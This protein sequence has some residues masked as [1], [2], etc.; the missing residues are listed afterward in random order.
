MTTESLPQSASEPH[1]LIASPLNTLLVLAL[2]VANAY[3]AV[4]H[5]AQVRSGVLPSRPF[6]YLRTMLFECLL[7]AIVMIGVR[8]RGSSLQTIFGQRWRSLSHMFRDLGLGVAFLMVSTLVVSILA[9]H[10]SGAP[11]DQS[12]AYLLPQTSLELLLWLVLS[13]VAGVCE[14]AV[15][16]GY[17]LRQF[18]AFTHSV[19]AGILISAVAFAATHAYQGLSRASVIGVTAVLSGMF[20]RWCGTV[21]P[22]MFAHTLQDAIAPL[23]IKL[24]RR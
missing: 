8:L 24:M 23:L 9:G 7:L 10:L 22:A 14:E 6:I 13:I 18:S 2:V 15:F 11:P 1:R 5:A 12:I 3:R 4:L 17:L 20:V 21:R 19:P 16:R